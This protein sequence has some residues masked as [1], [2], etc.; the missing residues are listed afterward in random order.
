M[1]EKKYKAMEYDRNGETRYV[2]VNQETGE[3]M[4]DARGYGYK[5]KQNAY[6]CYGYKRKMG[7]R[8]GQN[9]K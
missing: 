8:K 1:I 2:I 4:D 9:S 5:S 6:A 3:I 7:K